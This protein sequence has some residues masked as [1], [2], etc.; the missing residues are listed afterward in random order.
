MKKYVYKIQWV[1]LP[2]EAYKVIRALGVRSLDKISLMDSD[3]K[4][5]D[6]YTGFISFPYGLAEDKTIK[7]ISKQIKKNDGI[8]Y[9][10]LLRR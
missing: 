10:E 8:R 1:L 5:V 7:Y 9:I 6:C 2:K 3:Y 4:T